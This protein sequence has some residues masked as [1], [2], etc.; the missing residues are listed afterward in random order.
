MCSGRLAGF[1]DKL[2]SGLNCCQS[3]TRSVLGSKWRAFAEVE[4]ERRSIMPWEKRCRGRY[5]YTNLRRGNR[6]I[7]VYHGTGA[8][9]ELAAALADEARRKRADQ[10]ESLKVEQARLARPTSALK[11]LDDACRLMVETMLTAGGY[12]RHCYSWRRRHVRV[13]KP[14]LA[15]TSGRG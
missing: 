4:Q 5:Y 6:A 12:H 14:P 11:A 7:K 3:L 9:G 8:M 15:P 2:V 10:A 1:P 13:D